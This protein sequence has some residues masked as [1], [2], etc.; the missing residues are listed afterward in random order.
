MSYTKI[1]SI[2][3]AC[4]SI[5]KRKPAIISIQAFGTVTTSGWA[6]GKLI[7]Y[8]YITP[9][10]NGIQEFDFIAKRPDGI[11]ME[12]LTPIVASY[13]LEDTKWLS[14]FKIYTST[15]EILISLSDSGCKVRNLIPENIRKHLPDDEDVKNHHMPLLRGGD[16]PFPSAFG[17]E[18][19]FPWATKTNGTDTS[20]TDG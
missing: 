2:E 18:Y 9:P 3:K 10:E 6:E 15:N 1:H 14:A 13:H 12:V 4:F 17:E 11:V 8:V 5:L 7:P 16:D 19:P 20:S